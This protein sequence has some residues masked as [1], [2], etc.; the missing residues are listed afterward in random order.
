[1]L[2]W[3]NPDY[4]ADAGAIH[5]TRNQKLLKA[6]EIQLVKK[7]WGLLSLTNSKIEEGK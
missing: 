7:E 4:Y 3:Y 1:M 6:A 5:M 2:I